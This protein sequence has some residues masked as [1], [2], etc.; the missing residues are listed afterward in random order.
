GARLRDQLRAA[1]R[2]WSERGRP[3]GLLWRDE[4]LAEYR[5]WR[6]RSDAPLAE[7]EAAFAAASLREA[8]RGRRRRLTPATTALV[9]LSAVAVRLSVLARRAQRSAADAHARLLASWEDQGRE[10]M[11]SGDLLRGLAYLNA[12]Y[13]AGADDDALRFLLARGVEAL[14]AQKA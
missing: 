7:T 10:L 12:A 14:D 1:A 2:T 11:L 9:V 8:T 13:Q 3:R 6:A 5:R 4:A